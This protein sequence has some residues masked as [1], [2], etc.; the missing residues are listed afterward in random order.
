MDTLIT[1]EL[2]C[3][4]EDAFAEGVECFKIN[5]ASGFTAADASGP[6]EEAEICVMDN[7][8]QGRILLDI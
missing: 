8:E 6:L 5:I 1:K 2:F 3:A 4:V 7:V